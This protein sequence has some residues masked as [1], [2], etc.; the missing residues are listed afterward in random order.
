MPLRIRLRFVT[1]SSTILVQISSK[2]N[3]TRL[4]DNHGGKGKS[5][6][7]TEEEGGAKEGS[8]RSPLERRETR[9]AENDE[10]VGQIDSVGITTLSRIHSSMGDSSRR[11]HHAESIVQASERTSRVKEAE[12]AH[13]ATAPASDARRG[14]GKEG[15]GSRNSA[16]P[17]DTFK[18]NVWNSKRAGD[19]M[20]SR[21]HPRPSTARSITISSDP[22]HASGQSSP[23]PFPPCSAFRG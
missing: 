18:A 8:T 11:Q 15:R 14:G 10:S 9:Q 6:A 23:A 19:T 16:N 20:S 5:L 13:H 3:E 7:D 21:I 1:S 2:R 22:A 17:T 12:R 4:T